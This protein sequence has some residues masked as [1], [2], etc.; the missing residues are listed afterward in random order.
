M[1]GHQTIGV[2]MMGD[3]VQRATESYF[4][5]VEAPLAGN[6]RVLANVHRLYMLIFENFIHGI[7]FIVK[8]Q[9]FIACDL[10]LI[11]SSNI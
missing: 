10:L 9:V 4:C 5:K 11:T 1:D 3:A 6:L 7:E 8:F 2:H